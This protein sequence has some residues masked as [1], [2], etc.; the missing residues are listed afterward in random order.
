VAA[1]ELSVGRVV[2]VSTD[3][4]NVLQLQLQNGSKV[5]YSQLKSIY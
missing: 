5:A 4:A 3:A 1:T 2:S